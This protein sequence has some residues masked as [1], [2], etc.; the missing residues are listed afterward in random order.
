MEESN[1]RYLRYNKILQAEFAY[2]IQKITINAGFTCPNRDGS[3]G[4]GGCTYCNNHAFTPDYCTSIHTIKQQIADGMAFFRKKYPT[5]Q[6]LAYFQ[7]YTNTYGAIDKLVKCYEEALACENIV[8]IVVATR[9]DCI[10]EPLLDYFATLSKKYYVMIEYGVESTKDETLQRINRG[11]DFLTAQQAIVNTAKRGIKVGVHIIL[12]LPNE[13]RE[14]ML[15]HADKLSTLPITTLK[16][17]QLQII[18]NTT[19]ATEYTKHPEQFCLL[20]V[21]EYTDLV[22]D[23]VQRLHPSIA[24][25]RF[26]SQS[27]KKLL[28]APDWGLKNFEFVAMLE[29]KMTKQDAWQGKNY[30][31]NMPNNEK[32]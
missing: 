15:E 6:Y 14:T 11:H 9:P 28:I 31:K 26:V 17:H 19:M 30:H 4:I 7:S 8:G 5:Q 10:N 27:P 21:E 16:I 3:K 24:I 12:G 23:F 25:E 2:P 32:N 20:S 13:T 1:V 18:R 22:I 29:R